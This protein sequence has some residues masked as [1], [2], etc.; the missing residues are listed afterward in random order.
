[1]AAMGLAASSPWIDAQTNRGL[2]PGGNPTN[3]PKGTTGA[4]AAPAQKPK[5]TARKP[6]APAMDPGEAA[7][8]RSRSARTVLR[9]GIDYIKYQQYEKSLV[10]LREAERRKDQLNPAEITSLRQGIE[11]AQEGLRAPSSQVSYAKTRRP[12]AGSIAIAAKQQAIAPTDPAMIQAGTEAPIQSPP[13]AQQA[14][15]IVLEPIPPEALAKALPTASELAHSKSAASARRQ[16]ESAGNSGGSDPLPPLTLPSSLSSPET[17]AT[18]Q[19]AAVTVSEAKLGENSPEPVKVELAQPVKAANAPEPLPGSPIARSSAVVTEPATRDE[20]VSTVNDNSKPVLEDSPALPPL[21]VPPGSVEIVEDSTPLPALPVESRTPPLKPPAPE[22]EVQPKAPVV[23][24]PELPAVEPADQPVVDV[25]P[26]ARIETKPAQPVIPTLPE[27]AVKPDLPAL[28]VAE[29]VKPDL[30]PMDSNQAETELTL[31]A[32]PVAEVHVDPVKEIAE[33]IQAPVES[34]AVANL[35]SAPELPP[36]PVVD[37]KEQAAEA[38]KA[39]ELEVKPAT[40]QLPATETAVIEKTVQEVGGIPVL[41]PLPDDEDTSAPVKP[42]QPERIAA[43]LVD[44]EAAKPLSNQS[45][46]PL[47]DA[48][49]DAKPQSVGDLPVLPPL[50]IAPEEAQESLK[51]AQAA[52]LPVDSDATEP[53]KPTSVPATATEAAKPESAANLPPLPVVSANTPD[54]PPLPPAPPAAEPAQA[55]PMPERVARAEPAPAVSADSLP[56]LPAEEVSKTVTPSPS[57]V[58]DPELG[59][60]T[61]KYLSGLSLERRR[62]IEQMARIQGGRTGSTPGLSTLGNQPPDEAGNVTTR[63]GVP[64]SSSSMNAT[65]DPLVRLEL[66]RAPSPA[67]ARPIRAILLPEQFDN[68]KPRQFDPRRKMWAS[69]AVAHFP[70][71]FQDPSLERYGISVEQRLGSKGRRLTYPIDDPKQSKLRNQLASPIISGGLFAFQIATFP[72]RAIA[73]PPWESEYDLGYYR[74]G[75]VVPEDTV[76]LPWKGVGPLFKGNKY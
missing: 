15:R 63:P 20:S 62:E 36:L 53:L 46:P 66:P 34:K 33:P 21:S 48:P 58:G 40:V 23:E 1:M 75:D 38:K 4:E 50:P 57:S 30:K 25:Q 70:L 64:G 35:E 18:A 72:L 5:A 55:E 61:D 32:P 69:A 13:V 28:P 8:L 42:L 11:A 12:Q 56:A 59:K 49:A 22:T 74:P 19:I 68:L 51:E 45:L 71:Y 7:M 67:E 17:P 31:P 65:D 47:P 10:Y 9:N 6:A 41:T 29:P 26:V 3:L 52:P 73:D 39:V 60:I 76:V 44:E 24:T 37:L 54:S 14:A 43:K 16:Y 27:L 2:E